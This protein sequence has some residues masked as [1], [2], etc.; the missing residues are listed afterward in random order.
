MSALCLYDGL[1]ALCIVNEIKL[2]LELEHLLGGS[3]S[4]MYGLNVARFNKF[5]MVKAEG[6]Y[7]LP[8]LCIFTSEQVT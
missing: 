2:E 4:N 7:A 8:K 5:P 6:M 3:M 1:E